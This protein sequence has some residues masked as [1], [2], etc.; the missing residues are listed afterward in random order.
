MSIPL[1]KVYC[2]SETNSYERKI[3]SLPN[4]SVFQLLVFK[5]S[6]QY[7][8]W[9]IRTSYLK[10]YMY[11]D[12]NQ[13]C[14]AINEYARYPSTTLIKKN[15]IKSISIQIRYENTV[16]VN[17]TSPYSNNNYLSSTVSI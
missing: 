2:D 16:H 13:K 9:I 1:C 15:L 14:I 3:G 7:S 6:E 5:I 17:K 4:T 12:S 11:Y 10:I 8:V